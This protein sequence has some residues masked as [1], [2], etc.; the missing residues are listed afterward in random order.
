MNE[1]MSRFII[2]VI[3][4]G[5][6]YVG[7]QYIASDPAR[8]Q[9]VVE[10]GREITVTGQAELSVVPDIARITVGVSTTP[11]ASADVALNQMAESFNQVLGA[12]KGVGVDEDD[13][14]TTNFSVSPQYDFIDGRQV[15]R[16][17]I[18]SENVVV[19][20]RDLTKVG[21]VI[22]SATST[23]ANQ[24]GG[25]SF[26]IDEEEGVRAQAEE[27]AIEQAKGK[28]ERIAKSLGAKLGGVKS[29]NVSGGSDQPNPVAF[30]ELAIG[31]DAA[32]PEVPAGTNEVSVTVTITYQL[33]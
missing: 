20:V 11:L 12:V 19:T 7:G 18:A 14:K 13:V 17:F 8:E 25:I 23:G 27:A 32:I 9:Q 33:Q 3:I 15:L 24:I 21:E 5:L 31:G 22:S 1:Q 30:R 28:A 4:G 26:E 16:G 6:F 2:P 10:S 29:Y